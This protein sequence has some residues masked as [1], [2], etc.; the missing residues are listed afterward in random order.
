MPSRDS[1]SQPEADH[2]SPSDLPSLGRSCTVANTPRPAAQWEVSPAQTGTRLLGLISV[3]QLYLAI[4][5]ACPRPLLPGPLPPLTLDSPR[6]PLAGME[7]AASEIISFY[8]TRLPE[9]VGEAYQPA[10]LAFYSD[11][12]L[13]SARASAPPPCVPLD[14]RSG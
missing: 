3:L 6:F 5:S 12:W 4:E 8:A 11:Y 1:A 9:V 14:A 2:D 7:S 10:S 13:H